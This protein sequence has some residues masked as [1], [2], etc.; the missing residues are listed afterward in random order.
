MNDMGFEAFS[1]AVLI[2]ANGL[3]SMS[4]MAVVTARKSRLQDWARKGNTR[5]KIALELA[6]APNRVLS[7]VQVGITLVG[8][9]TGVFSG[10][11]LAAWLA[12]H[13]RSIPVVAPYSDA[14]GLALVVM[15]ITYFTLVIGELVLSESRCDIPRESR[16][17]WRYR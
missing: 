8:I 2:L 14:L 9:L 15:V 3:F 10:R 7:A 17:S 4:E 11:S 6:S 16:P 1:G 12:G 5:A 13:L